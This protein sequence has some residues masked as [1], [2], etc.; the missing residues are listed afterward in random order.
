M[1]KKKK[2]KN[3]CLAILVCT[4]L[5]FAFFFLFNLIV[6]AAFEDV[7]NIN[8]VIYNMNLIVYAFFYYTMHV[9]KELGPFSSNE[10]SNVAKEAKAYFLCEG[11]Y[12]LIIYGILAVICEIELLISKSAKGH[13]ISTVC[14]MFFPYIF[15][16]RIPVVRS[17]ANLAIANLIPLLLVEFR[18]FRLQKKYK[19]ELGG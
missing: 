14:S 9:K 17:I 15:W 2:I 11:K 6:R 7:S 19:N 4:V 16:I 12:L 10:N 5:S 3:L 1:R 13:F 8:I 18:F